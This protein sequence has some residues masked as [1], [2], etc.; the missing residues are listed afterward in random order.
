MIICTDSNDSSKKRNS[1]TIKS[2]DALIEN[3]TEIIYYLENVN[4]YVIDYNK[5]LFLKLEYLI[6]H[7]NAL[8]DSF[9]HNEQVLNQIYTYYDNILN[10]YSTNLKTLKD[11]KIN[12]FNEIVTN[13]QSENKYYTH[14]IYKNILSKIDLIS[15]MNKK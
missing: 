7:D 10:K 2:T 13:I 5:E 6:Q 15:D 3:I 12:I 1:Q 8:Y 14:F 4:N 11:D 9:E